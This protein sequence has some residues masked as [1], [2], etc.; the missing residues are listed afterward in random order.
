MTN[1][2]Q[3]IISKI[4]FSFSK[5]KGTTDTKRQSTPKLSSNTKDK[6]NDLVSTSANKRLPSHTSSNILLSSKPHSQT[7][8]TSNL[9]KPAVAP[10]LQLNNDIFPDM[11][12][13]APT[14]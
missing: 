5:L 6:Q 12:I 9:Q 7:K 1:Q 13:T 14:R 2:L 4:S 8:S 10:A 3:Q 11:P